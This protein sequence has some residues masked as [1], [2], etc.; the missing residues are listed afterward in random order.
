MRAREIAEAVIDWDGVLG[1]TSGS[2]PMYYETRVDVDHTPV[3]VILVGDSPGMLIRYDAFVFGDLLETGEWIPAR[4]DD[5]NE[6][7]HTPNGEVPF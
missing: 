5:E 6:C 1:P 7:I 4:W 3:R 2:E